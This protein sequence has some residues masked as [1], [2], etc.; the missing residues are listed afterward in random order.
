MPYMPTDDEAAMLAQLA[1]AQGGSDQTDTTNAPAA[2]PNPD[3]QGDVAAMLQGMLQGNTPAGGYDVAGAPVAAPDGSPDGGGGPDQQ[4]ASVQPSP[5]AGGTG[6]TV[7]TSA[8]APVTMTGTNDPD[9]TA[10][11]AQQVTTDPDQIQPPSQQVASAATGPDSTSASRLTGAPPSD[12]GGSTS[13]TS[14]DTSSPPADT[15]GTTSGAPPNS[16]NAKSDNSDK[17]FTDRLALA[18]S[19][20]DPNA[21]NPASSAGGTWQITDGTL[22]SIYAA[23]PELQGKGKNDPAVRDALLTDNKAVLTK[24]LQR[25]PTD[26]EQYSAWLLGADGASKFLTADPNAS[27]A[28]VVSAE[29]I[30]ANKGIFTDAQGKP[31]SVQQAYANITNRIEHPGSG[32]TQ[33]ASNVPGGG[34]TPAAPGVPSTGALF[35]Q[36]NDLLKQ[37]IASQPQMWDKL[38]QMQKDYMN[39]TKPSF[40]DTLNSGMSQYAQQMNAANANRYATAGGV[41]LHALP[42]AQPMQEAL[43]NSA[44]QQMQERQI[45]NQRAATGFQIGS[46]ALQA[47]QAQAGQNVGLQQGLANTAMQYNVEQQKLG[48]Q[49]LQYQLERAKF[50]QSNATAI[51]KYIAD[52]VTDPVTRAAVTKEFYAGGGNPSG[53]LADNTQTVNAIIAKHAQA[54]DNISQP[55]G[56]FVEA[57]GTDPN[58]PTHVIR[59]RV[60]TSTPAGQAKVAAYPAWVHTTELG[61]PQVNVAGTTVNSGDGGTKDA[62]DS[63]QYLSQQHNSYEA[64]AALQLLQIIK[65]NGGTSKLTQGEI[66]SAVLGAIKNL[67]G[68]DPL[69]NDVRTLY[70][71]MVARIQSGNVLE[72]LKGLPRPSEMIYNQIQKGQVGADYPAADAEAFLNFTKADSQ[73]QMGFIQARRAA[74][75]DANVRNDKQ[76]DPEDWAINTYFPQ[77]PPPT[78]DMNDVIEGHIKGGKGGGSTTPPADN[79]G[80]GNQTTPPADTSGQVAGNP[81]LLGGFLNWARRQ[82][83]AGPAQA[84]PTAPAAPVPPVATPQQM[85]GGSQPQAAPQQTG[86]IKTIQPIK[87]LNI[88]PDQKRMLQSNG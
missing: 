87:P 10:S 30:A 36:Q 33:T 20:N 76:F 21:K 38:A 67:T 51:D 37:Y 11:N 8:P 61:S 59:E 19:G 53:S 23:H 26:G 64:T 29:A 72:Q 16:T 70:T 39:A 40:F 60:D 28:S 55:T 32:S 49:A 22:Q 79:G 9:Q 65:Q 57:E 41:L 66:P 52:N 73:W 5:P 35:Q 4:M 6:G 44:N 85:Y 56:K 31:L 71:K 50:G 80:G 34:G 25:D 75:K 78:W 54:G 12:G 74:I 47:Q 1:G 81:S 2:Q 88:S 62:S 24:S 18:E 15:S 84:T 48:V 14:G 13:G 7:A 58:D 69:N 45:A 3:A 83:G 77:H 43:A 17:P 46:G 82:V 63:Q 68:M 27:V 86:Q 42:N